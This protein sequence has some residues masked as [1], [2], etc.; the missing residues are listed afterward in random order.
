MLSSQTVQK[1]LLIHMH[2]CLT[3]YVDPLLF[4]VIKNLHLQINQEINTN[5]TTA[6]TYHS[7]FISRRTKGEEFETESGH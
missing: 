7:Y 3:S 6:E 2:Q 1:L 5:N 4:Q